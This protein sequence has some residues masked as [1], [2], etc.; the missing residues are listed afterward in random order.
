ML[1]RALTAA[2]SMRPALHVPH[3][4]NGAPLSP[5]VVSHVQRSRGPIHPREASATTAYPIPVT[6]PDVRQNVAT[7]RKRERPSR[8]ANTATS[9]GM[10]NTLACQV[11]TAS[12]AL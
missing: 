2:G 5:Y 4:G 1:R 11:R 6:P 8:I 12:D 9:H 10:T 3:K 7:H